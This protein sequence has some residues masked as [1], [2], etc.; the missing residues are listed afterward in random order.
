MGNKED[1]VEDLS[2]HYSVKV[3]RAFGGKVDPAS[4]AISVIA[5][6]VT[7]V[8]R[9][10]EPSFFNGDFYVCKKFDDTFCFDEKRG[11]LIYDKNIFLN[12]TEGKII[13]QSFDD[14]SKL[15][16]WED[17]NIDDIINDENV[18]IYHYKENK[19]CFHANKN[20]ID[21]TIYNEGSRFATQYNDLVNALK[22][23]AVKK[24]YHSSCQ[25]FSSSWA[26]PSPKRLFFKGGGSGNNI[27]EEFMQQ[28]LHEFLDSHFTRGIKME[29]SREFN[30]IGDYTKPKPVDVKVHWREANRTALIEV[31][32]IGTI[33]K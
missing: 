22:E 21:I 28:S 32:F 25:H 1:I 13:I 2:N 8:F 6:C 27:P 23:Y 15:Y 20:E 16:M 10:F 26:E 17:E 5:K 24:I 33:K 12:K 7:E 31:K 9:Y 11:S 19:E 18:L 30:T 29:S 14:N 4:K 3:M